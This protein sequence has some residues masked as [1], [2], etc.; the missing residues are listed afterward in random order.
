MGY[1]TNMQKITFNLSATA[2]L[3]EAS[4][5]PVAAKGESFVS[6]EKKNTPFL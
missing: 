6:K 5:F 3:N 1:G 4:H 2:L